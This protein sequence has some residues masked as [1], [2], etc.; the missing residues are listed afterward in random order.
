MA[1]ILLVDDDPQV[2]AVLRKI[3]ELEGYEV[4]AAEDGC[5]A[6][7]LY[8]PQTIDLVVTDIVMPEKEGIATIREIRQRNPR[9]RIIAI[10]GGGMIPP[11][12]YL[13]WA[14]RFGVDHTFAKPIKRAEILQAAA[15]LLQ[16]QRA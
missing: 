14:Q 4:V 6:L 10:S 8:D 2:L 12:E 1:R 11:G 16:G 5:R 3:F 9:A 7:D 13:R 15:E